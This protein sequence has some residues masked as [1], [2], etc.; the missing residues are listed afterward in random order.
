MGK[1]T[2]E[3]DDPAAVEDFEDRM[4][5]ATMTCGLM[6]SGRLA[7]NHCEYEG[8]TECRR[9]PFHSE[10]RRHRALTREQGKDE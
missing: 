3:S 1:I 5:E 6:T 7:G 10:L 8:T 9:C 2:F 4:V